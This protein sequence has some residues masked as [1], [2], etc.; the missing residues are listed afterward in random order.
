MELTKKHVVKN[1]IMQFILTSYLW[2]PCFLVCHPE[3][4]VIVQCSR[5]QAKSWNFTYCRIYK[6]IQNNIHRVRKKTA[7]KHVKI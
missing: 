5:Q 2:S 7:P 6:S 4:A 1:S 3:V